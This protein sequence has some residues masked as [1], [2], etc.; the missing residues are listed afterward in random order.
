MDTHYTCNCGWWK[1]KADYYECRL[2]VA[3]VLLAPLVTDLASEE[4]KSLNHPPHPLQ[5]SG[6]CWSSRVPPR[7]SLPPTT[8]H[9]TATEPVLA[10]ANHHCASGMVRRLTPSV[11]GLSGNSSSAVGE[12]TRSSNA[13]STCEPRSISS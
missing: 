8:M 4:A 9:A 3:R 1:V 6:F 12:L 10:A 11:D 5:Y 7:V 13:V 2:T